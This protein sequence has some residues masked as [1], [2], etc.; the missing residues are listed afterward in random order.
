MLQVQTLRS[1]EVEQQ[2]TVKKYMEHRQLMRQTETAMA[3]AAL[4][5]RML[6]VSG[7]PGG[8]NLTGFRSYVYTSAGSTAHVADPNECFCWNYAIWRVPLDGTYVSGP[9]SLV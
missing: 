4:D 8:R 2:E 5:T 9:C 1:V 6:Q 7:R 3:R